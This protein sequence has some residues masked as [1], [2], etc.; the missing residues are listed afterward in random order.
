MGFEGPL[1]SHRKQRR[2][3]QGRSTACPEKQLDGMMREMES[4]SDCYWV[5]SPGLWTALRADDAVLM[6]WWFGHLVQMSL[7]VARNPD[8]PAEREGQVRKLFKFEKSTV[9]RILSCH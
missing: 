3:H 9:L 6:N 8:D 4:D 5:L 7:S 2:R 1:W